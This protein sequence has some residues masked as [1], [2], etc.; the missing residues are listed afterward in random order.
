MHYEKMQKLYKQIDNLGYEEFP[1]ELYEKWL[2]H[3]AKQKNKAEQQKS[4]LMD[5]I[6]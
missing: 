1:D 5:E 6:K 4:F 3:I 2:D